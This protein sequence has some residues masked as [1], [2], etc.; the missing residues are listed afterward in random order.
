MANVANQMR[1]LSGQLAEARDAMRVLTTGTYQ[2]DDAKA[3]QQHINA[4]EA[5]LAKLDSQLAKA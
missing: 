3:L 4:L 1:I 5:K 2:A